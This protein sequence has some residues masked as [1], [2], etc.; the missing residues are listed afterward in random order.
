M[1]SVEVW[2]E[3]K[4][5]MALVFTA[6]LGFSAFNALV[7]VVVKLVMSSV[8]EVLCS[9]SQLRVFQPTTLSLCACDKA[10]NHGGSTWQGQKQGKE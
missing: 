10:I 2:T 1:N 7:L 8:G 6:V 3:G 9:G 4:D 5:S